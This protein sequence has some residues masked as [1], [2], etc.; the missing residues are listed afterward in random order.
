MSKPFTGFNYKRPTY[1]VITP[2]TGKT[3]EVR[4]LMV[5]E[6]S[7]IKSSI[8]TPAKA[9]QIV[10]KILYDS[11]QEFPEDIK[12]FDEFKAKTTLRD[13]EAL[14]YALYISTFG[15]EQTYDITCTTCGEGDRLKLKVSQMFSNNIYPESDAIVNQYKLTQAIDSDAE[16]DPVMEKI[17]YEKNKTSVVAP[18]EGM[19][20]DI[21]REQY[22]DYFKEYVDVP[23][24]NAP[25][26]EVNKE[27]VK[28][29]ILDKLVVVDLPVSGV[30]A[31]IHQPTILDEE[32]SHSKVPYAM[33][34][35]L[36]VIYETL[37]IRKFQKEDENLILTSNEDIIA[38]Y[39]S[40]I[41]EDKEKI[42]EEFKEQFGQYGIELKAPWNCKECQAANELEIDIMIQFFR[43]VRS[44]R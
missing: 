14:M 5:S 32:L 10:N 35:Q 26:Q 27:V 16:Q 4:A 34:D 6:I 42:F 29:S 31:F 11:I 8:T 20:E 3:Y 38:G 39:Q 36:D 19:P 24:G 22:P 17:L 7:K 37:I 33:R 40:L 25:I 23:S 12:S 41:P 1:T 30:K 18:P 13:R 9:S 28:N 21:A 15:D 2:Q 43:M 44:G